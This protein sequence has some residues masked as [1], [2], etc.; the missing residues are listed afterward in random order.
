MAES[1]DS[2]EGQT[3][4]LETRHLKNESKGNDAKLCLYPL[5]HRVF[6]FSPLTC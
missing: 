3:V 4:S 6:F 1:S 5:L 2:N